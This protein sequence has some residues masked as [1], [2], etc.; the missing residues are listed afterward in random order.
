MHLKTIYVSIARIENV[1][2]YI[3]YFLLVL[4]FNLIVPKI[5]YLYQL[6]ASTTHF[7]IGA[8]AAE[9]LMVGRYM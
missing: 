1:R 9:V 8:Y 5:T 3:F 4:F 6:F 7:T 2:E